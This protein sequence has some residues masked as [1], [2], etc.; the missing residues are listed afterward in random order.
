MIRHIARAGAIVCVVAIASAWCAAPMTASE[1]ARRIEEEKRRSLEKTDLEVLKSEKMLVFDQGG[2]FDYRRDQYHDDD[3]DST[4]P[5]GIRYVNSFDLRYW[6]KAILRP[7]TGASYQ[8]VHYLYVRIKDLVAQSYPDD[9]KWK[10]KHDDPHLDYAYAVADLRPLWVEAGRHYVTVGR[11]ISYSDVNDAL[12]CFLTFPQWKCKGFIA[13]TL[14]H[15]DNI[16][17][18]VPGSSAGSDRLF[19][20]FE[21][22]Y[23]G[24][25]RHN[26]YSYLV[27]QRDYTDEEPEDPFH[28]YAYNSEYIG[29][30]A[31]GDI[32]PSLHYLAEAIRETGSSYIYESNE[33]ADVDAWAGVF[34][35]AYDWMAYSHPRFSFRY[36]FGTGDSG[37]ASVTDTAYGNPAGRDNNFL[38]FGYIPTGYALSPRLSNLHFLKGSASFFPFEAIRPLKRCTLGVDYYR[39]YKDKAGGAIY[40]ADATEDKSYVGD[41]VDLELFWQLFSDVSCTLQYGHFVPGDAYSPAANDPEDYFSVSV[42]MT[43]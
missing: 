4:T 16:D 15:E 20:G 12:Q 19:Y 10:S 26:F 22:A 36:A 42:T 41:E 1:D 18:S 23:S 32:V 31:H 14:P 17:G 21:G 8:N 2:W 43:F 40:D 30:G 3:N 25:P 33:K 28:D 11:G 29:I 5:D 6:I 13:H 38:Y 39:Y 27:V 34:E 35:V 24:I 7:P 9:N 37:R